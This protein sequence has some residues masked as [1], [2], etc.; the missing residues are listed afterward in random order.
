[1]DKRRTSLRCLLAGL[2]WAGMPGLALAAPAT[3]DTN[4]NLIWWIV[5]MAAC[6]AG[7]VVLF[8]VQRRRRK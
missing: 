5:I 2:L 3:G 8:V 7:L 6:V 1:M 4:P